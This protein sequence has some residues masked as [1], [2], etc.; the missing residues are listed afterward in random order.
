MHLRRKAIIALAV[1]GLLATSGLAYAAPTES[2][3][4]S[5]SYA[6]DPAFHVL[7]WSISDVDPGCVLLGE[8]AEPTYE[9]TDGVLTVVETGGDCVL[10]A[11]EVAGPNGQINHGMFMK[12]FNSLYDGQGGRGCLNRYLAQ[13]SLGK[14]DQQIKVGDV[15]PLFEHA[16]TDSPATL[17]FVT[18]LTV[19]THGKSG[20]PHGNSGEPH[21]NS[22]EPHGNSAAAPG[23]NK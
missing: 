20:E 14:D 22:G 18:A 23:H 6:Y 8:S 11:A 17:E 2:E 21:G 9:V 12:L 7:V 3:D 4:T 16:A 15:D 1:V 10:T 13:S 19:C 5:F